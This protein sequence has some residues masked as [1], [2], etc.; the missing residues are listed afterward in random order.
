MQLKSWLQPF[1]LIRLTSSLHISGQLWINNTVH[2]DWDQPIRLF[3]HQEQLCFS[4]MF[5]QI[6]LQSTMKTPATVTRYHNDNMQE[7]I[8]S[9]FR[10]IMVLFLK[11]W[12]FNPARTLI[13]KP[14]PTVRR[15]KWPHRPRTLCRAGT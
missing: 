6:N 7:R 9:E 14:Q 3:Q 4:E 15:S 11:A 1:S 8:F 12:S 5:K 10:F 13:C 2:R